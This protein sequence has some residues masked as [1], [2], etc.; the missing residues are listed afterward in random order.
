ML[1]SIPDGEVPVG[2]PALVAQQQGSLGSPASSP[3]PG[4]PTSSVRLTQDQLTKLHGELDVVQANM[5]VLN[6]MLSELSPGKEHPSDIQL[7][8]VC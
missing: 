8:R 4:V 7:L 5:A 3:T 1:Q 2:I 6:E